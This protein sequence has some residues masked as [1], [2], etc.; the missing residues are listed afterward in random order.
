MGKGMTQRRRHTGL[1]KAGSD[2]NLN[3]ANTT[4][5]TEN[6]PTSDL[7][8]N[9]DNEDDASA[10]GGP[11]RSSLRRANGTSNGGVRR[12]LNDGYEASEV[13]ETADADDNKHSKGRCQR[14][15]LLE[16]ILLLGLKDEQVRLAG[17]HDGPCL[18][19]EW[20]ALGSLVVLE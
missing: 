7:S 19:V 16:E 4:M 12:I 9:D 3:G 15:T 2:D 20:A 5:T 1:M 13:G 18:I 10:A 17:L 14:L 11:R 6:A 8:N